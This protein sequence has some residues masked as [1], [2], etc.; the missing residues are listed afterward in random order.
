MVTARG[1]PYVNTKIE[2]EEEEE[3]EEENGMCIGA[4]PSQ[5]PSDDGVE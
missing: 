2:E 3:E 1:R 5:E 4:E